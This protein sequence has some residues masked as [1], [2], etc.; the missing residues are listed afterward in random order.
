MIGSVRAQ[1][2]PYSTSRRAAPRFG[3]QV[4]VIGFPSGLK[5][6]NSEPSE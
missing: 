4:S 1:Q 2:K 6:M 3:H 5:K